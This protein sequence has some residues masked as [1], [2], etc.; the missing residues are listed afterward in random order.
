LPEPLAE[1]RGGKWAE[2]EG[3]RAS[4]FGDRSSKVRRKSGPTV[5]TRPTMRLALL[6]FLAAWAASA[7]TLVF[8]FS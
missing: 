6:A 3:M 1:A 8:F 7:F 5:A 2:H 4:T